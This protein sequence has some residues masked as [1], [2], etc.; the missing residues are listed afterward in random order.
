MRLGCGWTEPLRASLRPNRHFYTWQ[1][2]S[3]AD[4]HEAAAW[5]ANCPSDPRGLTLPDTP[6]SES[7]K[8]ARSL[9]SKLGTHRIPSTMENASMKGAARSI[10]TGSACQAP[11]QRG[12]SSP[13]IKSGEEG[14]R[15]TQPPPLHREPLRWIFF[16]LTEKTNS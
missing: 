4:I 11:A 14:A 5:E 12:Q 7:S 16:F 3:L 8:A 1:W 13:T 15:V 2:P 9:Q 10:K 6:A